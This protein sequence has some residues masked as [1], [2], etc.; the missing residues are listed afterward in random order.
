MPSLGLRQFCSKILRNIKILSIARH[1][2]SFFAPIIYSHILQ[3]LPGLT[4][5]FSSCIV[6]VSA[7]AYIYPAIVKFCPDMGL[8]KT[9]VN[10]GNHT[11][12]NVGAS[13]PTVADAEGG[14]L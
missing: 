2:S 3:K 12:V 11:A 5:P 6:K 4:I 9:I 8:H 10:I 14:V 1:Y 13:L 7:H